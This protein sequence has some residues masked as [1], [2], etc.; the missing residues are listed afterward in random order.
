MKVPVNSEGECTMAELNTMP[1]TTATATPVG[2]ITATEVRLE[3]TDETARVL[4]QAADLAGPRPRLIVTCRGEALG[5]IVPIR[6]AGQP[7]EAVR[8]E[9]LARV[10]ALRGRL[11]Y[12]PTSSADLAREK[13]EEEEWEDRA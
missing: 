8:S 12:L 7:S 3:V 1:G 13:A 2:R 5:E 10:R 4:R 11:A 6:D 9:H